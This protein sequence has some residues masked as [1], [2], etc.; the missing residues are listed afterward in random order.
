MKHIAISIEY[1]GLTL[2]AI[3]NDQGVYHVPLK[4]LSSL[5]GLQWATQ[6]QKVQREWL[7]AHLGV[8]L[9]TV[10]DVAGQSRSMVCIRVDRVDAYILSINPLR[11]RA[12]G[13]LDGASYLALKHREWADSFRTYC[14]RLKLI[15]Y[16]GLHDDDA[17]DSAHR[18]RHAE[19]LLRIE[20]ANAIANAAEIE[21]EELRRIALAALGIDLAA[22]LL[23]SPAAGLLVRH[24]NH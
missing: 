13:N 6:H 21:D 3:E 17:F 2:L 1:A 15:R 12:G 19:A 18:A 4:P 16:R 8:C 20:R 7:R 14:A 11:V 22:R 9:M 5:F 10:P 24:K 23:P